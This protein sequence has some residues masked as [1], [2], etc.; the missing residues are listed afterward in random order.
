MALVGVVLSFDSYVGSQRGAL[1]LLG[2]FQYPWAS[3]GL[4]WNGNDKIGKIS[5]LPLFTNESK[6]I[7]D[8]SVNLLP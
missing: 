2:K 1:L 8:S 7:L 6:I 3:A 4:N 5:I